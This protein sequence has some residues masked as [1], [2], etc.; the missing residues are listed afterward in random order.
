MELV[1][2]KGRT[3]WTPANHDQ[4]NLIN[5]FG[6]WET[7]FRVFSNIYTTQFPLKAVELL[8]YSHVIYMASQTYYWDNVYLYDKEFHYHISKHPQRSWSVILQQAWNLRLKDKIRYDNFS[9]D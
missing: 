3:F 8:Q 6:S 9:G 2:R 1:N 7:A 5:F 4:A